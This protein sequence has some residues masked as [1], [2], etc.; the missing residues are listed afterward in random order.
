MKTAVS[1]LLFAIVSATTGTEG[2][3]FVI[4]FLAVSGGLIALAKYFSPT[5]EVAATQDKYKTWTE[6]EA[7][8][9]T[10]EVLNNQ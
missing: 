2:V 5:A 10:K 8:R 3:L 6:A 7:D 4:G 9:I 1:I